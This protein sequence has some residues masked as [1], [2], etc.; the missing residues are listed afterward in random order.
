MLAQPITRAEAARELLR[1]DRARESLVDFSQAIDI[2][3]AP[4][5]EDPDEWLFKPIET[6]VAAHHR[7]IL[8][9]VQTCFETPFGRLIIMAPPGSAKSTYAGVVAP[10]WAM[11]KWPGWNA[12]YC[13]HSNP[14]AERMSRRTRQICGSPAYAAIWEQEAKLQHG[15]T[16][17]REWS[18]TNGS[19]ILNS[20]LEAGITSTR[21]DAAILDDVIGGA[22][23]AN[24]PAQRES[25]W[26]AYQFDLITRLKPDASIIFIMTR[27][28]ED[29]PIGRI[30]PK[31]YAGQS[32]PIMCQDGQVWEVIN[33]QAECE[34]PDDPLGRE[35][36][37]M[38]WPEW[39][40]ERH[41][42]LYRRNSRLWTALFQQRPAPDTGGQ[43]ERAWFKRYTKRPDKW[44]EKDERHRELTWILST[45]F[46]QTDP[47]EV[48]AGK[49]DWTRHGMFGIDPDQNV[50][51][52]HGI[53]FQKSPDDTI[54]QA[55]DLVRDY[56]PLDWLIEAGGIYNA[57]NK[58]ISRRM[59]ERS[60]AE[61]KSCYT[62]LVKMPTGNNKILKASAFRAL[63]QAGHVYVK[64]GPEGDAFIAEC[65]A[66]PFGVWDDR[67]DIG[68][69]I[70]RHMDEMY[71][72][73]PEKPVPRKVVKHLSAA[74][75]EASD[76]ED[77]EEEERRAR[78]RG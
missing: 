15:S 55:I 69:Q 9:K 50:Y 70:G 20:G 47:K 12:V 23:H 21:A 53:G 27:W 39:F 25:T 2:P 66:F 24:S 6:S 19:V 32:G 52:E 67:V 63:C 26:N 41:W 44:P 59:Q 31:D 43:F 37:E 16:A 36:G 68:G 56:Q 30:L 4:V 46:A 75:A 28:H 18:L 78:F 64:E 49:V 13:S 45:D 60:K 65:C 48:A 8:S 5:S 34:R 57:W 74:A 1:R 29:D 22:E 3:G 77:E 40:T 33:L 72:Q 17:V 61:K 35:I 11:G 7:L 10:A 76:I 54:E 73:E 58:Y 62:T 14:P 38:L 42:N 51:Y 71:A